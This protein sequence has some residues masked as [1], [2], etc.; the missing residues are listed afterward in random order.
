MPCLAAWMNCA[1]DKAI[2]PDVLGL[3]I[4][5]SGLAVPNHGA[6]GIKN[7]QQRVARAE[8]YIR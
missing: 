5:S 2:P 6:V 7:A 8:E 4:R 1:E 3:G